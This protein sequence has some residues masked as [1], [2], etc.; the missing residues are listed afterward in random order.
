MSTP[1]RS[2]WAFR[3][4]SSVFAPNAIR[5]LAALVCT[6]IGGVACA[7]DFI[8]DESGEFTPASI[9]E[10]GTDAWV[11]AEAASLIARDKPDAARDLLDPW[12]DDNERTNN[13]WLPRAY[14][15]RG[16]ARV[17]QGDEYK[18]LYDYEAVIKNFAGSEEYETAV[19][20]EMDIGQR[21]LN[22]LRRKLWGLVRIEPARRLGEELMIR[23]QERLPGSR[24]SEES[25][26]ILAEHY[27]KTRDL[28]LAKEMFD[29]FRRNYP[30]S[31]YAK[32]AL[33]GQI[34]ANVAQFKGPQYDASGLIEAELLLDR[35]VR[36]YPA[37]ALRSGIAEGLGSRIDES[38]A[39]QVLSTARWYLDRN[40]E[41]SARLVFRRLLRQHPGTGAAQTVLRIMQERG[42]LEPEE[43]AGLE[44]ADAD[45]ASMGAGS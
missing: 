17:M 7:Q 5:A 24:V 43:A 18:A 4:P 30:E 38:R 12:I 23:A 9:P 26:I 2:P 6:A 19:L 42:W 1:S 25:A 27:Y 3:G 31:E 20:R 35:F 34:Y 14:R 41:P 40:D 28:A 44:A 16:D 32:E 39:Q 22:G 45:E 13:E 10:P 8:L 15:L 36:Q 29:I 37:D 33:L 11:M 21:Y